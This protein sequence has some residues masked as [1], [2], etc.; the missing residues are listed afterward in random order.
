MAN[1]NDKMKQ[2]NNRLGVERE[3]GE[4]EGKDNAVVELEDR[5]S[6]AAAA[7]E[8][9]QKGV[10]AVGKTEAERRHEEQRRKRVCFFF[11]PLF[12]LCFREK[13]KKK[14]KFPPTPLTPSPFFSSCYYYYFLQK[15]H[16]HTHTHTLENVYIY[17]HPP[18]N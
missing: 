8:E 13:K 18:T 12:L 11:P 5:S 6:G 14:K 4:D 9:G 16:T 1:N 2:N 17:T 7:T 3:E 15:A 10:W